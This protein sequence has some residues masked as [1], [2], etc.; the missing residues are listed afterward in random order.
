MPALVP[1]VLE[2]GLRK[3]GFNR[4]LVSSCPGRERTTM[5]GSAEAFQSSLQP[6]SPRCCTDHLNLPFP[7]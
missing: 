2:P 4:F 3:R 5:R 1:I 7:I 6:P